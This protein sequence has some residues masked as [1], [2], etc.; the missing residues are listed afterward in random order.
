MAKVRVNGADVGGVWTPPYRVDVT[1][2][3]REGRNELEIEVV[4]TWV[5][6]LVSDSCLPEAERRTWS[7]Y[8]PYTPESPLQESGLIGP[9][10]LQ[11]VA[12]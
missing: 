10:T 3:L 7:P 4:N 1:D 6:R 12:L 2:L 8:N 11:R 5:N 9:V